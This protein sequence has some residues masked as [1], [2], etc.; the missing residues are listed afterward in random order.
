MDEGTAS[1][2]V[3]DRICFGPIMNRFH[4]IPNLRE[5]L[6]T[7]LLALRLVPSVRTRDICG[8]R[9]TEEVISHRDRARI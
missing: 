8:R 7:K 6:L 3:H 4:G 1:F 2:A 5:K 9:G